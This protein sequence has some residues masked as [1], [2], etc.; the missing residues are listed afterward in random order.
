MPFPITGRDARPCVSTEKSRRVTLPACPYFADFACF[1]RNL[2]CLSQRRK[3]RKEKRFYKKS[4][5]VTPPACPYFADF[6]CFARNICLSLAKAQRAQR[7][8]F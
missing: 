8:A 3:G 2:F 1:A 6:A 5:R 4:R 7:K